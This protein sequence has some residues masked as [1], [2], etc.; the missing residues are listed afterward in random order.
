M[1]DTILSEDAAF[2]D[3]ILGESSGPLHRRLADGITDAIGRG[4]LPAGSRLPP[5]RDLAWRLKMSPG[6]VARAYKL[7]VERGALEA[8]VGR[9]TFVRT[10]PQPVFNLSGILEPRD[11]ETIDLRG[12]QAVNVGQDAEIGAALQRLLDR[13]DGC[14]PLTGYRRRDDDPEANEA[15]AGWIRARG[16]Q[17]DGERLI[18]TSGAQAAVVAI[19]VLLARGGS[20]LSLA[21]PTIHP[22]LRDAAAAVG[23]RLEPV[24]ADAEGPLPGALDQACVR[25]KPDSLLLTATLH[26]PTLATMGPERRAAIVAVARRNGVPIIE[27]DV[28]GWLT[29]TPGE[30]FA[31]LAPE[32]CWYVASFSKC[33]AAG[34]RAGFAVAPPGRATATLRA[35]QA[36]AHQTPWLVTALAAELVASGAAEA[37]RERVR[38]ETSARSALAARLLG[39][40]GLRTDPAV[41]FAY[42]PLE[43]DW[44]SE[45][46]GAAAAAQGVLVPP[47][48][49]YKVGR[50]APDFARIALGGRTGR[51][52]LEEGLQRLARILKEGPDFCSSPT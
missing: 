48:S 12:N 38:A 24:A 13:H 2:G 36:L 11:A 23:V 51:A 22:G 18:V 37:I 39:P 29:E 44:T 21:P 4:A 10:D 16:I 34:V 50:A 32:L 30:S 14:P 3:E 1:A 20:G 6:A 25:H 47:A 46:F 40:S 31:A 9:G 42:L 26:N 52:Q 8:V 5:I 33:V 35:Y 28:Y 49:I 43:P 45:E 15:L 17:A 19:L 27:D 41:S 7:G